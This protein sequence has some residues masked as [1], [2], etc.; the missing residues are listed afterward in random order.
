MATD[1]RHNADLDD[2]CFNHQGGPVNKLPPEHSAKKP[3]KSWTRKR[4]A[5]GAADKVRRRA[6]R[7]LALLADLGAAERS[8]VLQAAE[9]LNRA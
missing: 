5:T 6:F 1:L 3:T 2:V 4:R 7:V 8:R 9:R